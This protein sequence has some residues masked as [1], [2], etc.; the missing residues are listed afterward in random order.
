MN[1]LEATSSR[2]IFD[3]LD[4]SENTKQDYLSRLPH[5]MGFVHRNGITRDLLL[6][7]KKYL[8]SRS[9]L[10]ISAK[11]KYLA[12]ARIALRELHRQGHISVDLSLNIKSFQQSRKHKV[13]GLTDKEVEFLF[14]HLKSQPSNFKNIRLR[15]LIALLLFQGLRQVE[16]VR[17][18]VSD[19]NL[20][21]QRLQVLGKARDDKEY[22]YL[23]SQTVIA[24]QKYLK[25]S[26]VKDGALFTS[27]WGQTKGKRLS[28]RGLRMII[29][30]LFSDIGI[31]RT[32]HGL[33]HSFVTTLIKSYKS[34]LLRV[35]IYTR[36]KSVDMLQ[37]YNDH[38]EDKNDVEKFNNSF[39]YFLC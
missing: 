9:D 13:D 35:S 39:K 6:D 30:D 31:D 37:V 33:R 4:I 5:F 1:F 25:A 23:H 24:L 21:T 34:D 27:V 32:V 20:G 26:K 8:R 11:N 17:L 12:V 16:V 14:E 28:T 36:H 10:G 2:T 19:V 22:I 3:S 15:A 38:I 7:Y 18:N 29:S